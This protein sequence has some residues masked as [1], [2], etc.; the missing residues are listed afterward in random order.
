MLQNFV[1]Y[2]FYL[3]VMICICCCLNACIFLSILY[4]YPSSL[5]NITYVYL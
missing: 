4:R 1:D 3:S 2:L 5:T